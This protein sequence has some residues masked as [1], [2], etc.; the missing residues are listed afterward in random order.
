MFVDN[1]YQ[2]P[3]INQEKYADEMYDELKTNTEYQIV[4]IKKG[5]VLYRSDIQDNVIFVIKGRLKLAISNSLGAEKII[6][7][8]PEKTFCAPF[9]SEICDVLS[10]KLIADED[11]ELTYFRRD[12]FVDYITS[13]RDIF[14]R[15]TSGMGKRFAILYSNALDIQTET[16]K[17]RVYNLIYQTALNNG[18]ESQQGYVVNNFPTVNDISLITGVHKRNIYKY[19]QELEDMGIIE[20]EKRVLLVKDIAK[21]RILIEEGYKI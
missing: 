4:K 1:K 8:F 5:K 12:G 3:F 19:Y 7:F 14:N 2:I 21:L 10:L 15:L 17:N 9:L 13:N 6:F 11:S 18:I 16:S 20:R